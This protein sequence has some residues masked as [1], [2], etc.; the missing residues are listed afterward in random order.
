MTQ[1][2]SKAKPISMSFASGLYDRMLALQT[3]EVQPN[4]LDLTF[5]TFNHPR[6]LFD[7]Q[8]TMGNFD[9][10]EFSASEYIRGVCRGDRSWVA[11]PVFP[12]RLFRHG[13]IV[14]NTNRIKKPGDLAGA[15]VGVQLYTMTAAVYIRGLLQH[16]Y[17]VDVSAIQW[18]E[19][20][21]TSSAAYGQ[22]TEL[23]G[24]QVAINDSGKSLD[25]L[26][27][28]GE[29]DAVFGA[30]LPAS[31]NRESHIQRLFPD[32]K[33]EE[34]KYFRKTG[35]FPIMHVVIIRRTLYEREPWVAKSLFDALYKSKELARERMR[36]LSALR[37]MLPWLPSDLDEIEE[38]FSGDPW[39]YGLEQNRKTLEML[40]R[41]LVEQGMIDRMLSLE[42]LFIDVS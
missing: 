1:L 41:C 39:P 38:T 4:Q 15:R 42:E 19:G 12:S 13:F 7:L 25:E 36:F 10:S 8:A 18:V 29:I 32:F 37:Y 26:L 28:A 40:V 33:E 16:E 9:A 5:T 27:I 23:P 30:E 3:G 31:L 2:P 35:I 6:V 34:K 14:V 20:S 17:D 22:P 24:V 11:I 21:L